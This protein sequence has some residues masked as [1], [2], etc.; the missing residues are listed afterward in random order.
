MFMHVHSSYSKAAEMRSSPRIF[1]IAAFISFYL[2]SAN[3]SEDP[4]FRTLDSSI[5]SN[6][7]GIFVRSADC[8]IIY[9]P[10]CGN[11]RQPTHDP[12]RIL[13]FISATSG[14]YSPFN[15]PFVLH[16]DHA[17]SGLVAKVVIV[18]RGKVSHVAS[19][20]DLSQRH[21]FLHL[22]PIHA[23]PSGETRRTVTLHQLPEPNRFVAE[24]V[25]PVFFV[26]IEHILPP[27]N[28]IARSQYRIVYKAT[29]SLPNKFIC[30]GEAFLLVIGGEKRN[31]RMIPSAKE[32]S[33]VRALHKDDDFGNFV[34][35][36]W[37]WH[38][39]VPERT[40]ALFYSKQTEDDTLINMKFT[41]E[42][43]SQDERSGLL[44]KF[45]SNRDRVYWLPLGT[46]P[47][48]ESWK[49]IK[50]GMK[51]LLGPSVGSEESFDILKLIPMQHVLETG[52]TKNRDGKLF[53]QQSLLWTTK[54]MATVQMISILDVATTNS[55]EPAV[56]AKYLIPKLG[57]MQDAASLDSYEI[58]C[59]PLPIR[60]SFWDD[61]EKDIYANKVSFWKVDGDERK[62]HYGGR[63][64]GHCSREDCQFFLQFRS[65]PDFDDLVRFWN[66]FSFPEVMLTPDVIPIK[67]KT[68]ADEQRFREGCQKEPCGGGSNFNAVFKGTYASTGRKVSNDSIDVYDWFSLRVVVGNDCAFLLESLIESME[69]NF[70]PDFRQSEMIL[71]TLTEKNQHRHVADYGILLKKYVSKVVTEYLPIEKSIVGVD[72]IS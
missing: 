58:R 29:L 30:R 51:T 41:Y 59:G 4:V 42:S 16:L 46:R 28:S 14:K 20:T 63:M 54:T 57:F 34:P 52:A 71:K 39:S 3:G 19:E 5:A 53:E 15:N 72:A 70:L 18:R 35:Q 33:I 37:K 56:L 68:V 38:P 36:G 8:R 12:N 22:D 25:E 40:V 55:L 1:Q 65:S 69:S 6:P 62:A 61:V 11:P 7:R 9:R 66:S 31:F 13:R 45:S 23:F 50:F 27:S 21:V 67:T 48:E 17:H 47:G 49:F 60:E 32:R 10:F 2:V 43:W 44:V 26:D 64:A 24:R